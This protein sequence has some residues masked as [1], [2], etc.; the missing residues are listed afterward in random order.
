MHELQMSPDSNR[1][2][3]TLGDSP[4]KGSRS[5]PGSPTRDKDLD[6][7][8]L[9]QVKSSSNIPSLPQS[10][11]VLLTDTHTS[12]TRSLHLSPPA[13]P[14]VSTSFSENAKKRRSNLKGLEN[15]TLSMIQAPVKLTKH[16]T[17][18]GGATP[19]EGKISGEY[20][21]FGS[22]APKTPMTQEEKEKRAWEKE[23]RRR[24]KAKEKKR[25]E[26]IFV[27]ISLPCR[28]LVTTLAR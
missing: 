25:Q 4:A 23:K 20:D 17:H 26:Q 8:N 12:K 9:K 19:P 16:L 13:S 15:L 27:S 11:P 1:S 21:Y 3:T 22:K 6:L 28:P 10:P 5:N 14:P 7:P 18:T 24:K 2:S